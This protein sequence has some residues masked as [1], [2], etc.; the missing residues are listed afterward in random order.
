LCWQ[1]LSPVYSP[2][3]Q[4]H[5]VVSKFLCSSWE[6]RTRWRKTNTWLKSARNHLVEPLRLSMCPCMGR[7]KRG[8][9]SSQKG[10]VCGGFRSLRVGVLSLRCSPLPLSVRCL[11]KYTSHTQAILHSVL[12]T[13]RFKGGGAHNLTLKRGASIR[14]L[15]L[16]D[17]GKPQC[18]YRMMEVDE[19]G[20]RLLITLYK[21]IQKEQ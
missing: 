21:K 17:L 10:G 13:C 4:P 2:G 5:L 1:T 8:F 7:E 12:V 9:R 11:G 19:K 20:K 16:R 6:K 15:E 14:R 3:L 18:P